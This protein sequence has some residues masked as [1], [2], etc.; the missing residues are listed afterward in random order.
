DLG[1][2]QTADFAGARDRHKI[3]GRAARPDGSPIAG[4]A[5]TLSGAQSGAA[6]TDAAGGFSFTNLAAGGD[7]R[8]TLS[9]PGYTFTPASQTFGDLGADQTAL[10]VGTPV[11]T[12]TPTPTP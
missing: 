4:A 8:V 5:V 7:Y 9:L 6:T 11:P 3:S 10:F 2:D 12:P 1:A